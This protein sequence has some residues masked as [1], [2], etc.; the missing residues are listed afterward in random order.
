MPDILIQCCY[1]AFMFL[2]DVLLLYCIWWSRYVSPIRFCVLCCC[3]GFA[4]IFLVILLRGLDGNLAIHGLAWHG[5]FFLF[6]SAFLMYRQRID[7]QPRRL[8][9][10]FVLAFGCIYFG[11]AVN[12]L[13]FEP[14]ALVVREITLTTPKITKPMTIVFASDFQTDHVGRY[15]RWTLQKIKEQNADLILLGGDYT[16]G[17]SVDENRRALSD[18]NQLFRE[19]DLH[20][21]LGTY[22]VR[23][24]PVHD[25]D[26]WRESFKETAIVPLEETTSESIGE[27]RITFLSSQ[28]SGSKRTFSDGEHEDKFR[29]IVGHHPHYAMATQ[30]AELLLAGHTHGGQVQIPFWGLPIIT[31]SSTLPKKWATGTTPMPNGALLIVSHGTG[32]STGR[33]APRVRFHCRPDFWV[34]RLEP[35]ITKKKSSAGIESDT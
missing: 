21:P 12:T 35:A 28:D 14:T 30:E 25:W 23:G 34:I 3:G 31:Y 4:A 15:E 1:H 22:A 32:L 10:S 17:R 19:I 11:L 24:T 2:M 33:A 9:P 16:Q 8:F 20:A 7:G 5:T 18:W 27:I 26:W 6:A 13:L 29:L